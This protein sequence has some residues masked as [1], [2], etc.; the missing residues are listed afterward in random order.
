MNGNLWQPG[1]THALIVAFAF[2]EVSRGCR[3][4]VG[5]ESGVGKETK[6]Y[7]IFSEIRL[8]RKLGRAVVFIKFPGKLDISARAAQKVTASR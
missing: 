2:G 7:A 4:I 6:S 1:Q 3:P 5:A 8:L